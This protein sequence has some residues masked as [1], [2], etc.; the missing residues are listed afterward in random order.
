[1]HVQG[2]SQVPQ[3][4]AG[5][6]VR[7]RQTGSQRMRVGIAVLSHY[8]EADHTIRSHCTQLSQPSSPSDSQHFHF[9]AH[10]VALEKALRLAVEIAS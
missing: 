6:S 2:L 4:N 8:S 5:R 9:G 7:I 10:G 1:M 3:E